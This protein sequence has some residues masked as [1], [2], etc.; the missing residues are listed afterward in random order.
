[1]LAG[2]PPIT[3]LYMAFFPVLVYILMGTSR[4]V[5]MGRKL[6]EKSFPALISNL[7]AGTFSVVCLMTKAIVS[8]H[9]NPDTVDNFFVTPPSLSFT[10]AFVKPDGASLTS[11]QVAVVVCF[12]VG[13]W[14]VCNL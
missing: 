6:L 13:F 11:V 7:C 3:G 10:D 9:A 12:A 4:H 1:M 14:Q 8:I 2:V 5:S